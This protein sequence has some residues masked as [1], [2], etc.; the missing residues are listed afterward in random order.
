M[1]DIDV[2]MPHDGGDALTW[3]PVSPGRLRGLAHAIVTVAA[4][5]PDAQRRGQILAFLSIPLFLIG[6]GFLVSDSVGWLA[7]PQDHAAFNVV[8]DL[9]FCLAMAATWLVNRRGHVTAAAIMHLSAVSV[10]LVGFFYY[11]P[12]VR[13]EVVFVEPVFVAAFV[14]SPWMTFILAAVSSASFAALNTLSHGESSLDLQVA[15][16]LFGLAIIAYLVAS[17]LQWAVAALRKTAWDLEQD[18]VARH[19]AEEARSQVESALQVAEQ[20]NRT[21]LEESPAGVFLYDRRLLVTECNVRFATQLGSTKPSMI[22]TDCRSTLDQHVVPAME[23]ALAGE[24]ASYEGPFTATAGAELWISLTASPLVGA[25]DQVTGGIGVLMDRSDVRQ[26]DELVE[27]LAYRDGVTGLPNRTL[28]HDRLTQAVAQADRHGQHTA[29]GVLNIDRFKDV[30]DSFGHEW[31]DTLLVGV[32]ERIE[33]LLRDG[34]TVARSGG[35]EFL[36]LFSEVSDASEAASVAERVLEALRRPWRLGSGTF[37][38]SASLGLAVFPDDGFEPRALLEHAYSAMR[39]VKQLGGNA[40]ELYDRRTRTAAAERLSLESELHTAI[41]EHQFLVYYQPQID[42]SNGAVT[43]LEALVR[44]QHPTRGLLPPG[45]FIALAEETGLIVPLGEHVLRMACEEALGWQAADGR[46]LPV[47]VN[48]SGRQLRDPSLVDTITRVLAET[49]LESRLLEIEL[50]ETAALGDDGGS[51]SVLRDLRE[52]GIRIS[53]DDFG[54]GYSS[55]SHLRR[56][57]ISQLKIDCHFVSGLP[58]DRG[59]AAVVNAIIGLGE[60]LGLAVVAEGVETT[61]QVD[62]LRAHGCR[63]AQGFFFSPPVSGGALRELLLGRDPG[64]WVRGSASLRVGQSLKD[65]VRLS[66]GQVRQAGLPAYWYGGER[67][68]RYDS[69]GDTWSHPLGSSPRATAEGRWRRVDAKDVPADGWVHDVG[70]C[71]P[72]CRSSADPAALGQASSPA[73]A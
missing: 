7:G 51:D 4:P 34:D 31:G 66:F 16:G 58:T 65:A 8:T 46:P 41:D 69:A 10:C 43:G 68:L 50:T 64:D 19:R 27:R 15:L 45:E 73:G 52:A 14:L 20:R 6:L 35:D 47:A 70:C 62:F 42:M 3:E 5:D 37:Y 28:F 24:V 44:W 21:L 40:Q 54:T 59:C 12:A 25:D 2:R 71:C 61:E 57:P 60:S 22:G 9:L 53:L 26:A 56:L 32:G 48:V 30:N 33:A 36:V 49:H 17:C 18:I 39:R 38:V 13:I 29:V 72:C 55:L 67:E 23:R 11:T 1:K 63:E